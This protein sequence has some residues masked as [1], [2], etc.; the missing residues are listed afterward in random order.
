MSDIELIVVQAKKI[1][2]QDGIIDYYQ[3]RCGTLEAQLRV[4]DNVTE[5]GDEIPLSPEGMSA[6]CRMTTD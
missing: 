4:R 6:K 2:E 3:K 1:A 5:S